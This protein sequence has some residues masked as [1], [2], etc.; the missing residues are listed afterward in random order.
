MIRSGSTLTSSPSILA[1]PNIKSSTR[2]RLRSWITSNTKR[3]EN[4]T[5]PYFFVVKKYL[6]SSTVERSGSPEKLS[7]II[8]PRRRPTT[9][10]TFCFVVKSLSLHR[11]HHTHRYRS[12][13][14][15]S[16][17]PTSTNRYDIEYEEN[18][19]IPRKFPT[20]I[21]APVGVFPG[22]RYIVLDFTHVDGVDFTGAS[23]FL[24]IAKMCRKADI[25]LIFSG[26]RADT[27]MSSLLKNEG[28][29]EF[30]FS[31]HETVSMAVEFVEDRLL[32]VAADVRRNWLLFEP[33]KK[34]HFTHVQKT[35]YEAFEEA[36]GGDL[37]SMLSTY[38]EQIRLDEGDVLIEA[39]HDSVNLYLIQSGRLGAWIFPDQ[40]EH[41]HIKHMESLGIPADSDTSLLH[42]VKKRHTIAMHKGRRVRVRTYTR[43][44]FVNEH[45]LAGQYFSPHVIVADHESVVRSCES[46]IVCITYIR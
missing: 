21:T 10:R 29:M 13:I 22:C 39:G 32:E 1:C 28:V 17:T 27:P 46:L 14:S 11:F 37:G 36:F 38:T 7:N 31:S 23:V 41:R 42:N 5:A 44:A 19:A 30:I 2:T 34:Y 6:L 43:G 9:E 45:V 25:K 4:D 16:P 3:F 35:S 40:N 8:R 33:L 15:I 26:I 12:P 20:L 24:E 18:E